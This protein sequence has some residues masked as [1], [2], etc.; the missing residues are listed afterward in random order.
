M[1]KLLATAA[2]VAF[3][4]TSASAADM[5]P[6]Y[7]APPPIVAPIWSWTGFYAG[8]H[9]GGGFSDSSA[10][11]TQTN[12]PGFEVASLGNDSSGVVGGGQIGYNWQFAPNWLLGIEGDISGTG[13]RSTNTAPI[14]FAGGVP[15]GVGF[16]HIADRNIDWMA[17][18]RGRLGWVWDRW[19]VYGTGGAAWADVNYRNDLTFGGVF[20]PVSV[21]KTL[22]GWVAGG[23]VEYAVSNNWTV[24]AEYLY[25]DF[26]DET[27][28]NLSPV[29][30]G[31]TNNA[32][33][34][35]HIHVVR[36]GV[37]YKF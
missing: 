14:L 15:V 33:W 25:Y 6:R 22:S 3:T 32:T 27:V 12:F 8:L 20:N 4:I 19:M 30:V 21:N 24:R 10:V 13:I 29:I 7:K 34:D 18:I 9:V 26:G 37:N 5:A 35:N 23:G 17:S 28:V 1:R 16:N 36:A 31:G 2:F 11:V